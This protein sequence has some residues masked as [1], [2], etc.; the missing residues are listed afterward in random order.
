MLFFQEN[1]NVHVYLCVSFP[2]NAGIEKNTK[3]NTIVGM[4]EENNVI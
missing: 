2:T 4:T 1:R 3:Q